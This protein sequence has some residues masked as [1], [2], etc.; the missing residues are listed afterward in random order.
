MS[1]EATHARQHVSEFVMLETAVQQM[2]QQRNKHRNDRFKKIACQ[3]QNSARQAVYARH[4][5]RAGVMAA[6]VSYVA[7]IYEFR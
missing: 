5:G 6:V 2:N 4:I 3:R 7:F 1:D